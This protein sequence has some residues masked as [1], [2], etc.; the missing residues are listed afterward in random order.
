MLHS[1]KVYYFVKA[2]F[3]FIFALMCYSGNAKNGMCY[4]TLK[5][6]LHLEWADN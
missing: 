2:K 5:N 6:D 1:V 3:P 4:E